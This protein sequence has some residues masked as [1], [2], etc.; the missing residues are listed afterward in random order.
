M[1]WVRKLMGWILVGMAIY[2]IQPLFSKTIG[3]FAMAG[4]A[5]M[6]GLHLGWMDKTKAAFKSFERV[7]ITVAMMALVFMTILVGSFITQGPGASFNSYDKNLLIQAKNDGKPV[8]IDFS[9]EWCSPCRELDDITFHD[10]AVVDQIA[11]NF[12]LIKVDLTLKGNPIH[13]KLLNEY[14][15]KG[16]PTIVFLDKKGREIKQLRLIDFESPELFLERLNKAK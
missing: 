7:K 8:I 12:I 3:T 5:L 14:N 10:D 13:E 2:F 16:V 11:K 15:I 6:A 1:L 4:V 9:A